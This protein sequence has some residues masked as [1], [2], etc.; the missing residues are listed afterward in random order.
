MK[1]SAALYL[2]RIVEGAAR[3][4][5]DGNPAGVVTGDEEA[6]AKATLAGIKARNEAGTATAKAVAQPAL[7]PPK[8]L[9][10][11]DLKAA[12]IARRAVQ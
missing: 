9:P 8:R 10:L 12:A 4:D 5:L 11:A 7:Q 2:R 6:R 3:I 1:L